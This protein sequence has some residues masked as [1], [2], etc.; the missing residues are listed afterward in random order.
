MRCVATFLAAAGLLSSLAEAQLS[1]SVGPTTS[2]AA[3][4]AKKQCSVL[5]YGG[6]ADGS[7]DVGPAISSAWTACKAGG[8]VV[9][10]AGNYNMA[11]W[12]TLTGGT[13]VGIQLDGIISRSTSVTTGGNMFMIEH[14]TD[15]ELFSST[16]KGAIQ[17][18]G[19]TFH[20]AGS[21]TGPRILRF[22]EVTGFSAHDIAL[23]DA[24]AFH[25]SMDTCTNG[26]VGL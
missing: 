13:G 26:E 1:G 9:I 19:Y 11:T 23:V 21:I 18:N 8:I 17:G 16:G 3:K 2:T 4:R 20:K 10:P 24:P 7:T 22:Y 12:V 15:F 6:K 5:D 25:F 14:T